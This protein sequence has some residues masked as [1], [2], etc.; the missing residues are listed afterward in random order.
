MDRHPEAEHSPDVAA[1]MLRGEPRWNVIVF[2]FV[3]LAA[4]IALAAFGCGNQPPP[5]VTVHGASLTWTDADAASVSGYNVYR[6]AAS[7]GPYS[8]LGSTSALKYLDASAPAGSTFFYIVTSV[9]AG[10]ESAR[11]N[12]VSVTVP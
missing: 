7:G 4:A 9:E 3:V 1:V 5:V 10:A 12:E 2:L 6:S 8:L 11:S